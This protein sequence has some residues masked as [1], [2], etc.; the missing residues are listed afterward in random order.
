MTPLT[1]DELSALRLHL[2]VD[3]PTELTLRH[4]HLGAT[5]AAI[6]RHLD[7]LI[8]GGFIARLERG[9]DNELAVT[10]LGFQALDRE[11]IHGWN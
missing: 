6:S 5:G 11:D 2:D 7:A 3:E 8:A 10:A 1:A 9:I 4:G